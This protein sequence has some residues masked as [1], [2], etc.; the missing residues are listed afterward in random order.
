MIHLDPFGPIWFENPHEQGLCVRWW[1]LGDD[2]AT[3]V[4]A[5]KRMGLRSV[6]LDRPNRLENRFSVTS[7]AEKAAQNARA[8]PRR[9]GNRWSMA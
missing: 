8:A 7:T 9:P 1:H 3:D 6:H 5:A 2:L 4:D